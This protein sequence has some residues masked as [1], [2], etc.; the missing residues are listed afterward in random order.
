MPTDLLAHISVMA[1]QT[2]LSREHH[3]CGNHYRVGVQNENTTIFLLVC[4][5]FSALWC[6]SLLT[7][8]LLLPGLSVKIV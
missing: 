5:H 7:S 4:N 6:F 8:L 1:D 3:R 2:W